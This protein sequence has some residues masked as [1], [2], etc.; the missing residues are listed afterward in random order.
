MSSTSERKS[1]VTGWVNPGIV[2]MGQLQYNKTKKL[3]HTNTPVLF[4][5][6]RMDVW[7]E[8]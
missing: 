4:S 8:H 5:G 7:L 6:G 1:S 2:L 3:G